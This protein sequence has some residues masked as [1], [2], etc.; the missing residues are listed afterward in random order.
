MTWVL[1][2]IIN[3]VMHIIESI[4]SQE[5]LPD[6]YEENLPALAQV[7][8]YV[9]DADYS[10]FTQKV[11]EE[12]TKCR[13]KAVRLVQMY[14]FKFGE[15]FS[16]YDN[17]FFEKIWQLVISGKMPPCKQNEKLIQATVRYLNEKSMNP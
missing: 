13:G 4:L 5:E 17:Y 6:F 7:L 12:V 11:P 1:L 2:S 10:H 16:Q 9:L 3:S 15:Y 8:T 14:T